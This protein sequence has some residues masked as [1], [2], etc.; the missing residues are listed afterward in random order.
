MP[1]ANYT[2][3]MATVIQNEARWLPEWLEYNVAVG[4]QKFYIYD[5]GSSDELV[6]TLAPYVSSGRV[7][8]HR[9]SE[10]EPM[11]TT[12]VVTELPVGA[13][14]VTPPPPALPMW[15]NTKGECI[16]KLHF[17]QQ[18]AMVRHALRNYGN[19]TR[20]MAFFDVDEFF[21]LGFARSIP[22]FLDRAMDRMRQRADRDRSPQVRSPAFSRLLRPSPSVSFLR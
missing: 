1:V 11:P 9:V 5:D 4:V 21:A 3:T 7:V 8:L 2:L 16:T 18:V 17:P 6:P 19:H 12:R 15:L 14:C 20:W 10:L 13:Q 22:T